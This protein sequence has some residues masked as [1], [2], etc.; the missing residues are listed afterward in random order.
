MDR[1]TLAYHQRGA[2][3]EASRWAGTAAGAWARMDNA[4]GQLRALAL[5]HIIQ[6]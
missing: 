3:T 5:L 4:R 6:M 2:L 1:L